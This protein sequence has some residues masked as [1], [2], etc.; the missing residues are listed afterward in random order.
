MKLPRS[1]HSDAPRSRGT[2]RSAAGGGLSCLLLVV[3]CMNLDTPH[4]HVSLDNGYPTSATV[5][6]VIREG[7]WQA[8][9]FSTPIP[10]GGSSGLQDT[11]PASDNT[12]YVVLA[13]G[14]DPTS[15]APPTSF[16]VLQSK[17]GFAVAL[18]HTLHI[19]VN[20]STFAGNCGAG[21]TLTQP[22][23]DFIT[24]IAF[25]STFMGLSYD[26]ATCTTTSVGD[27]G[28]E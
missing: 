28:T 19:P 7:Y 22:Q 4:T 9:S 14:W 17:G 16:V 5:P 6:L 15:S 24:Q 27:A 2:G 13:P 21:S 25:P 18:N 20:D 3:G 11:V 8:V 10:P 1:R 23:A 12:A 26:A